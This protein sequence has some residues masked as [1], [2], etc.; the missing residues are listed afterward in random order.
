CGLDLSHALAIITDR[1]VGGEFSHAGSVENR[2][3]RPRCLI[4][5]ERAYPLLR[6]NVS[7]V[8]SKQKKWIVIEQ[9]LDNRA[10]TAPPRLRAPRFRCN[11]SPVRPGVGQHNKRR[12]VTPFV[13]L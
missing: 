9:I 10:R 5:P 3:A 1:A 13:A 7:L 6:F 2:R 11:Q 8:V 12:G 4:T